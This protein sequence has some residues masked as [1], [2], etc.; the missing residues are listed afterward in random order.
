VNQ[1]SP[2]RSFSVLRLSRELATDC[3]GGRQLTVRIVTETK[4]GEAAVADALSVAASRLLSGG[5]DRGLTPAATFRRR[6]A[7]HHSRTSAFE[8]SSE[9]LPETAL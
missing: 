8:V 3:S 2:F 5:V 6:F 4:S 9:I 7:T 1:E